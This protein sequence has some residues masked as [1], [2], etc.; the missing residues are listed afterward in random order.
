MRILRL[1]LIGLCLALF[2]ASATTDLGLPGPHDDEIYYACVALDLLRPPHPSGEY[3]LHIGNRPLPFGTSP[4]TGAFESYLLWPL[5]TLFGPRVELAR[6]FT[7]FLGAVTL[8]FF[9]FLAQERFGFW[10]SFFALLLLSLDAS[11]LFYSKLDC[12]PILEQLLWTFLLFWSFFQWQ[13]GGERR[14]LFLMGTGALLGIY[15]HI[16]FIWVGIAFGVAAFLFYRRDILRL[17]KRPVLFFVFPCLSMF[18]VIFLYWL[19]GQREWLLRDIPGFKGTF[20]MFERLSTMGGLLPDILLSRRMKTL[21]SWEMPRPLTD[22]FL[23]VSLFYF[24]YAKGRHSKEAW[25]LLCVSGLLLLQMALTPGG[26]VIFPH[27]M[28][29][30]Y[31]FLVLFSGAAVSHACQVLGRMKSKPTLSRVASIGILLLALLSIGGQIALKQKGD[32]HIRHH[33]GK[34]HWSDGIYVVA[35]TVERE[36]WEEIVCLDWGQRP[37]FLLT[38]GRLP[39]GSRPWEI[40]VSPP[41]KSRLLSQMLREANSQTLFLVN[42]VRRFVGGVTIEELETA[43]KQTGKTLKREYLFHDREGEPIYAA[44]TVQAKTP[45]R[46]ARLLR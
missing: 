3:T 5:F 38:G 14:Y 33:G 19:F 17:F 40:T 8:L 20:V 35:E 25:F 43:V 4:H 13:R 18:L 31:V 22:I 2:T 23:I 9:Y 30:F 29:V 21:P 10:G 44:Y 36:G 1:C 27:R 39:I 16:A 6:L 32:R 24:F 26:F 46:E 41:I 45:K 15:N 37:L 11:F 42:P 7:V 12:G 28:M 34:G